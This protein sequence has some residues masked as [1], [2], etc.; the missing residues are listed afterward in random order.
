[1]QRR[2]KLEE[3]KKS[4]LIQ[5]IAVKDEKIHQIL[6]SKKVERETREATYEER[7]SKFQNE[8]MQRRANLSKT[9]VKAARGTHDR[10]CKYESNQRCNNESNES[11]DD[12]LKEG[13]RLARAR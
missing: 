8:V 7:K 11:P 9:P 10:K 4:Q 1:M 6:E 13:L 5:K 2:A 3:E 12:R